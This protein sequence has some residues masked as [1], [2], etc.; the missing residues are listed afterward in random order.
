M[1]TRARVLLLLLLHC[2]SLHVARLSLCLFVVYTAR[3]VR[4]L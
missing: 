3:L 2:M 4:L 1:L